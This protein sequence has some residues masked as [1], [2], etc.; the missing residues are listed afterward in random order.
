MDGFFSLFT[1]K[2][3]ICI[4]LPVPLT[5][6]LGLEEHMYILYKVE[7]F[8]ESSAFHTGPFKPRYTTWSKWDY[9]LPAQLTPTAHPQHIA[10][11]IR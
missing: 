5:F 3:I 7:S 11:S 6:F 4:C 2:K 10:V 8:S 9:H 1:N